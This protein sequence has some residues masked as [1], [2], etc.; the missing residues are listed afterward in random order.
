MHE[1]ASATQV[2]KKQTAFDQKKAREDFSK[3]MQNPLTL[4]PK[5]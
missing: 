2:A 4:R 1:M 5:P 3:A